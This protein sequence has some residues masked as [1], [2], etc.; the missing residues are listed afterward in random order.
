[1]GVDIDESLE[2]LDRWIS[3]IWFIN[4]PITNDVRFPPLSLS[5]LSID[6]PTGLEHQNPAFPKEGY[7]HSM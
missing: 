1:M 6:I 5:L 3:N 7:E 4:Q 2:N